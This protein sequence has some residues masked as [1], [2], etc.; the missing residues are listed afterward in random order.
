[1]HSGGLDL[2]GCF[3]SINSLSFSLYSSSLFH[4]DF[5]FPL[6]IISDYLSIPHQRISVFPTGQKR[7]PELE[8]EK[9]RAIER[10]REREREKEREIERERERERDRERERKIEKEEQTVF[11]SPR[12]KNPSHGYQKDRDST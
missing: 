8:R 5:Q 10:E 9:A 12:F 2:C 7:E 4:V 3:S 6:P 1:L 11:I